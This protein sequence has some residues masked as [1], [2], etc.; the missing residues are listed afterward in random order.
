MNVCYISEF[1]FR[2]S[3]YTNISIGVVGQL[4]RLGHKAI[5]LGIGYRGDE[6]TLP[7]PVI[8]VN[9][10]GFYEQ[11]D[12][13]VYNLCADGNKPDRLII[14]LDIPMQDRLFNSLQK[15]GI[16]YVGIFP[17]EAPPLTMSWALTLAQMH[18]CVVMSR[19]G[20]EECL[21][22]GIK[23]FY[24]PFGVDTAKWVP[25]TPEQ[26]S[27]IRRA[28]GIP[29]ENKVI[30]TVADNQERK[31]LSAAIEIFAGLETPATYLM[32]TKKSSPVGW[33]LEDFIMEKKV[34]GR[35]QLY[36]RGLPF[37]RLW[38]LYA[39]ADAFL[40]TS[41]AEGLGMPVLEAMSCGVPVVAP[42]HTSFTEHLGHGRG[43]LFDNA[44]QYRDPFGNEWR[45]FADIPKGSAMLET[46]LNDSFGN[47]KQII[48]NA[49]EY[50]NERTWDK[51]GEVFNAA[52]A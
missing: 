33:L 32:V 9:R 43:F 13:M 30:L 35:V 38:M 17:L 21:H 40:I 12:A 6:H 10:M 3:G 22:Q 7:L 45:H 19:Y 36:D 46:C 23:A 25:G 24:A 44:Y 37:D 11:L 26:R 48:A 34:V 5:A 42:N 15:Y 14:A 39:I 16:P 29:P 31:N 20:T 41:K 27:T 4:A 2:G 1:D 18:S 51:V 52:L 28:L 50:I 47:R 49:Y 8:P